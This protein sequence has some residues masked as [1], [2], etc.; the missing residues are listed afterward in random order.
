MR[1]AI[2]YMLTWTTYGS[3]LQGDERGYVKDGMILPANAALNRANRAVMTTPE[4]TLTLR[5]QAIVKDALRKEA[6]A[7]GQEICAVAVGKKHLHLVVTTNGL[8]PAS[9]VSHYKN[10]ARLAVQAN[11]FRGRLWTRGYSKRY[12]FDEEQLHAMVEYV[13]RHNQPASSQIYSG[14]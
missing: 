9:A 12:C 5:Q 14:G 13:N 8:D 7:L 2:A 11:G 10:A 4:V 3:W 6:E 1:Q